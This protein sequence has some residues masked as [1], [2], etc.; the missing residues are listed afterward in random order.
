MQ[1]A[2][3]RQVAQPRSPAAEDFSDSGF[4]GSYVRWN[5]EAV[6]F[7]DNA[8][9]L[10]AGCLSFTLQVAARIYVAV[11]QGYLPP[12]QPVHMLSVAHLG[13]RARCLCLRIEGG[14]RVGAQLGKVDRCS[15]IWTVC[16]C[17]TS[18]AQRFRHACR[19]LVVPHEPIHCVTPPLCQSLLG[20]IPPG[21]G[22]SMAQQCVEIYT[23]ML[24]VCEPVYCAT[25]P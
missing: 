12:W 20:A 3:I 11:L 14:T 23:S 8:Q 7:G 18:A 17:K 1:D 6:E 25:A 16:L 10:Q 21:A 24:L 15:V 5:L 2:A 4:L 9:G 13:V 19:S 22:A